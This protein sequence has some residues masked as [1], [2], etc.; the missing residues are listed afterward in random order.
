MRSITSR[1]VPAGAVRPN[2]IAVSKSGMPDSIMVG[3][4]GR[5]PARLL[6]VD[7]STFSL[8]S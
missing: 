5:M 8:P 2:Q 3:R 1:G 6:P 7:A 4:S